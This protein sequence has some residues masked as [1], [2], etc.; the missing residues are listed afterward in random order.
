M[1]KIVLALIASAA[2]MGAAQAQSQTSS[3]TPRGYVG[4]GV[5]SSDHNF[6][7][8]GAANVDSDGWKSSGKIFGGYEFNRNFGVEAGYTDQRK[9]RANYTLN[10]TRGSA[11]ASGHS[12]YLAGKA[13]APV[14]ERVSVYGKLGLARNETELRSTNAAYN[15]DENKTEAY[16]AL[17]VQYNFNRNWAAVAEYER[18]GGKKDFG[19]N[20][21]VVTVGAKYSF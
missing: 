18:Y 2:A 21:D 19:A 5:A 3:D 4:A 11:E 15:R 13:T 20:P 10:G 6:T 9:S 1:K 14:N 8:P 17:G 16:G 12:V 7:L